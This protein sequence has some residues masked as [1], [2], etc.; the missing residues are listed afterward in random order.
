[1]STAGTDLSVDAFFIGLDEIPGI[2]LPQSLFNF[3]ISGVGFAHQDVLFDGRVEEH[4]LLADVS[5][6]LAV[7]AQVDVFEILAINEYSALVRVIETLG[8][9]NCG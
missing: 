8:K 7:I 9:L 1:M 6:L 4:G 2:G 3:S 5:N